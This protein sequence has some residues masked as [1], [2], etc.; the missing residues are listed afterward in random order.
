[1][2]N[3]KKQILMCLIL[4]QILLRNQINLVSELEMVKVKGDRRI[5]EVEIG[6]IE[7]KNQEGLRQC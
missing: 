7:I 5:E 6:T 3:Q 1:N 2:H 4:S